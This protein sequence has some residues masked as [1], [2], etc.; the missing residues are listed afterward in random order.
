MNIADF[1]MALKFLPHITALNGLVYMV[2]MNDGFH[3]KQGNVDVALDLNVFT[4]VLQISVVF[5]NI[6]CNTLQPTIF[7]NFVVRKLLCRRYMYVCIYVC[8]YL[9]ICMYFCTYVH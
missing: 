1:M 5:K 6:F 9:C 3:Q 8:T 2:C 4:R 7:V